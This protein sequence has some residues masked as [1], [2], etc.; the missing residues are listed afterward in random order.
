M[1]MRVLSLLGVITLALSV[2]AFA[3]VTLPVTISGS[4]FNNSALVG[5]ANG[6]Y[7]SGSPSY[8]QLAFTAAGDDAVVGAKGPFGALMGLGM[9]F[10]YSNLVAEMAACRMRRL[11]CPRTASG[12]C[13]RKNSWSSP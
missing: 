13:R 9:S 1:K 2:A 5:S 12:I 7:V 11:A 10:D 3:Q 4:D 6:T 8:M